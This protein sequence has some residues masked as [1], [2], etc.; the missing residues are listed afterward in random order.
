LTLPAVLLI[1]FFVMSDIATLSRIGLEEHFEGDAAARAEFDAYCNELSNQNIAAQDADMVARQ[2][3]EQESN[4]Q[5]N[6]HNP[7]Q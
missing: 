6:F 4:P 1:L 5:G 2:K 7:F 3:A